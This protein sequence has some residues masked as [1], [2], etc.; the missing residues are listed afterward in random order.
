MLTFDVSDS[1]NVIFCCEYKLV[2]DNPFWLVVETRW[3]MKLNYL[4]VFNGQVMTCS[5]QM[6]NLQ[7]M[8]CN[9]TPFVHYY[10]ENMI[11]INDDSEEVT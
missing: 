3:R 4:V 5:F 11:F 8:N 10:K 1:S 7:K 6:G 2:V 9:I